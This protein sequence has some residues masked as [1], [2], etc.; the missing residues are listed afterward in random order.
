MGASLVRFKII[1]YSKE[2]SFQSEPLVLVEAEFISQIKPAR[3]CFITKMS[4]WR[5]TCAAARSGT[6]RA[7]SCSGVTPKTWLVLPD[8]ISGEVVL[9]AALGSWRRCAHLATCT[10]STARKQG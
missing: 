5:F 8:M 3:V 2:Q 7:M 9:L 4:T 6:C 10:S 1:R